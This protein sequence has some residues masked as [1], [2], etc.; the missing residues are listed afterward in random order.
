MFIGM[1]ML[2]MLAILSVSM[3][4]A[5][6]S[7]VNLAANMQAQHALEAAAQQAI[8]GLVNTTG[9]F[10]DP[11]NQTGDWTGGATTHDATVNGYT[12][13]LHKPICKYAYPA[14]GYSAV[15]TT[16]PVDDTFWEVEA[17][18]TDSVTGA[19]TDLVQGIK[20]TLPKGNC[21]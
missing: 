15:A 4:R 19:T 21:P 5:S 13:T 11:I 14:A 17:T 18:A 16:V 6:S 2:L 7:N 9:F 20:I 10:N 8:E 3:I 1:L 12:V